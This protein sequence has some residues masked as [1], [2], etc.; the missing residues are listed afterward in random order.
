MLKYTFKRLGSTVLVLFLASILVFFLTVHSG[1]PLEDL[2]ESNDPDAPFQMEQ[3]IYHMQLDQ[4]WYT[5]YWGWLQGVLGCFRLSCDFGT[6][7]EG[8]DLNPILMQAAQDSLRLVFIATIA[9]IVLGILIGI[10]T[11][12]R[13]Y[14]L[15]DYSVSFIVFLFF[16]LPTFWAAVLAK[17][18]L[19]IYFNDWMQEGAEFSGGQLL[20]ISGVMAVAVPLIA[21]GSAMRRLVTGAVVGLFSA[22]ALWYFDSAQFALYPRVGALGI[23]L[24]SLGLAVGLTALIAG[25][26][27]RQVLYTALTV[28]ALSIVSYYATWNLLQDPPGGWFFL[29]ALFVLTIVICVVIARTMGGYAKGQATSVAVLTGVLSSALILLDHFMYHWP[30]M[31]SLKPRPISTIGS[32]T[33]RFTEDDVTWWQVN[34]DLLT[35]LWIPTVI[36]MLIS[37]ATYTRYTRSSM[38]EVARQDYIRTARAKGASERTV[39]L[40]HAF[41]NALIPLATIVAFDFAGL[42][43]GTVVL[44]RIFNWNGMGQLFVTA[45]QQVDPAPV[46]GF[47]IITGFVAVLFNFFA[48]ILYAVLDPR[49]RV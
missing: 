44:E 40:K 35:Q 26:K 30:N 34:L 6:N 2:R 25:L 12:I 22:G 13:Q 37:L 10:L 27:N 9:S 20:L 39:V 15:F 19:A 16:S 5:R 24:I 29:G 3:R 11:A 14:S 43:G 21:G 23:I 48:D 33:R 7:R 47:M 28:A 49:I 42:I 46:M 4:P 8:Q 17:D 18:Y 41:R 32:H 45:L 1:D 38:L 36:L 31:M